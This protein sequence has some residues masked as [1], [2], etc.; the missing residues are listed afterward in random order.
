MRLKKGTVWLM[1]FLSISLVIL[2]GFFATMQE[3]ILSGLTAL[4]WVIGLGLG[5]QVGDSIQ[6]SALYRPEMDNKKE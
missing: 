3:V 4:I 6:K 1:G 2:G 5:A